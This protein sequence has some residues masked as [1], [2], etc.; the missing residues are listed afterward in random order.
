MEDKGVSLNT[1]Q[2]SMSW[3]GADGLNITTV[4]S[5]EKLTDLLVS[6]L[7]SHYLLD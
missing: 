4:H 5:Q 3:L 2:G 7:H 6:S 1:D